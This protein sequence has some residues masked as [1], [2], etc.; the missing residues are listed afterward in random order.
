MNVRGYCK[1][2]LLD[3]F[4]WLNG[5]KKRYGFFFVDRG[6]LLLSESMRFRAL[7]HTVGTEGKRVPDEFHHEIIGRTDHV[8]YRTVR[9]RFDLEM[10]AIEDEVAAFLAA[11]RDLKPTKGQDRLVGPSHG[12]GAPDPV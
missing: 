11:R 10:K 7:R 8:V 6:T 9:G 2:A 1:W 12:S 4:R 3:N 5:Y